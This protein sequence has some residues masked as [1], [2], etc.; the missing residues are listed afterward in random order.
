[1]RVSEALDLAKKSVSD[2]KARLEGVSVKDHYGLVRDLQH[3]NYNKVFDVARSSLSNKLSLVW[4]GIKG[5]EI[6]GEDGA[7]H[8]REFIHRKTGLNLDGNLSPHEGFKALMSEV[9]NMRM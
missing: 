4:E 5:L 9:A 2:L 8:L 7:D 3:T 1:M 6:T